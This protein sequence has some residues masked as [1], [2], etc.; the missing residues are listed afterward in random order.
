MVS[1]QTEETLDILVLAAHPDD[2]ELCCGGTILKHIALGKK[3]GILDFTKG[4]LGTR[5]NAEIRL[6]ESEK[7]T[8]LMGISFRGNLEL[9]DGFFE[10]NAENQKK[11]IR[12]IR[13][14]RPEIILA[15]AVYDRH[16]DHT[17]ASELA[18][19][20]CF[21]SGLRKI[22]TYWDDI[23]QEAWRPR[24]VYH[25]VQDRYLSPNLVVDITEFMDKKLEVLNAFSSQFYNP[26]SKEP[27]S[28]ISSPDFMDSMIA[29]AREVGK[30][31]GAKFGESFV[32]DRFPGV[33]NLFDLL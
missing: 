12:F 2:A 20:S 4:E 9:E 14:F 29:R 1:H 24:A 18:R 16:P 15:N 6:Q 27:L 10:N 31:I 26:A 17:R 33:H 21:Y 8:Q 11:I 5:G 19:E 23:N 22:I 28:Y 30:P 13:K 3:V 7:A 32:M 25:Y